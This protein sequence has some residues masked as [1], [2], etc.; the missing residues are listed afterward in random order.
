MITGA[1]TIIGAAV[2]EAADS[3]TGSGADSGDG[4]T[5]AGVCA[6]SV[7]AAVASATRVLRSSDSHSA[8]LN[9]ERG[10]VSKLVEVTMIIL[11]IQR[12]EKKRK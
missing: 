9:E 4:S 10:Q 3:A 8:N 5:C 6:D 7:A 11:T 2:S 1:L 12:K